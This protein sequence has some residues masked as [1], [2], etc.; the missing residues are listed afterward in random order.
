MDDQ[1]RYKREQDLL[2][3]EMEEKA[4]LQEQAITGE[5]LDT[6]RSKMKASG[7]TA[8]VISG[9]VG[10]GKKFPEIIEFLDAEILEKLVRILRGYFAGTGKPISEAD[11]RERVA[12]AIRST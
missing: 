6:L 3:Q 1:E 12:R 4:K 8:N 5:R 10:E 7:V 11:A 9:M 2:F